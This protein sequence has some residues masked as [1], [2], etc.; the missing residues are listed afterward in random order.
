MP[1]HPISSTTEEEVESAYKTLETLVAEHQVEAVL[2]RAGHFWVFLG[3]FM[4]STYFF[5]TYSL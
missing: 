3:F 2:F 5:K 1:G 4:G